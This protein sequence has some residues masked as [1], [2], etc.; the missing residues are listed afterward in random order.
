[1]NLCDVDIRRDMYSSV[2]LTGEKGIGIGLRHKSTMSCVCLWGVIM[3]VTYWGSCKLYAEACTRRGIVIVRHGCAS[4]VKFHL[5]ALCA[6]YFKHPD[7]HRTNKILLHS[8]R[9]CLVL[10]LTDSLELELVLIP[11]YRRTHAASICQ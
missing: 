6:P 5:G 8:C 4:D 1:V 10:P 3:V 9:L 7:T 2:V 11:H